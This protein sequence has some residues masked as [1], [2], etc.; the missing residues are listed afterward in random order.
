MT[1]THKYAKARRISEI[2]IITGVCVHGK[3]ETNIY[4]KTKKIWF[5]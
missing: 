1:Q 2:T 4:F 3:I 5:M